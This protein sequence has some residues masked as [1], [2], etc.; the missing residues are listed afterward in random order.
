MSCVSTY[1]VQLL[2]YTLKEFKEDCLASY[3]KE[4]VKSSKVRLLGNLGNV[5]N[6]TMQCAAVENYK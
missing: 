6:S 4:L 1:N 3:L 5:L 2:T